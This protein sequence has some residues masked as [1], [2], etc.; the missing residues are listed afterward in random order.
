MTPFPDSKLTDVPVALIEDDSPN[1]DAKTMA[2]LD[3][4]KASVEGLARAKS[5]FVFPNSSHRHAA[6]VLSCIV[7]YSNKIVRIYDDA[8]QGDISGEYDPYKE[9]LPLIEFHIHSKKR[10]EIVVRDGGKKSSAIYETLER[11]SKPFKDTLKV[12]AATPTFKKSVKE[13]FGADINFAVGDDSS[14]RIEQYVHSRKERKA[15]CS[16]NK[17]DYA[18][19]ISDIFDEQL[20]NCTPVF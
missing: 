10:L 13:A 11:L 4:Y 12:C 9:L 14:F 16:F 20:E 8:L 19:V 5:D 3:E 1:L 6:I 7:K 18:K 15:V 2:K 17:P